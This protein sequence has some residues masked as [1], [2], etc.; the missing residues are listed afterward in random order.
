M[1]VSSGFANINGA[2]IYYETRGEG[3]AILLIHAGVAD[4]RMWDAQFEAFAAAHRVIRFDLRG[5]GRSNM[6]AG[7]FANYQDVRALLDHLGVQSAHVVAISFGG[8][9]ALDFSL[10]YPDY[11]DS[12]I[13][14]APSVSGAVPS[15]R[16]KRFW[17]EEDQ[18]LE[19]GDLD[20]ATEIN[21]HLW[22]DGPQRTPDQVDPAVR[23]AVRQMQLA[24]F[25]KEIPEDIEE[26]DLNPPAIGRLSEI[27]A[28]TLILVGDLDLH[29]KAALSAR[30]AAE[31]PGARQV[32]LPGVAHMLNMERPE[33]FNEQVLAFLA[34]QSR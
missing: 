6:P 24:I 30:L 14:G 12:L 13:L 4:S 21:L 5:F 19:A 17:Q 26:I 2:Q 31:I 33:Q 18:A 7:K 15:Q 9:I 34:T 10:A 29:E 27:T 8:A 11:V 32:V 23:E 25:H 22:V 1:T 16:I 28:P 3:P 20:G